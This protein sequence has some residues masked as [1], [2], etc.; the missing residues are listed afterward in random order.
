MGSNRRKN[1]TSQQAREPVDVERLWHIWNVNG[2]DLSLS[3]EICSLLK[4]NE[5]LYELDIFLRNLPLEEEYL[6]NET[7]NRARVKVAFSRG[8]F[9][10][11]YSILQNNYFSST[12]DLVELWDLCHYR[13]E[14]NRRQK[15]L[16]PL[17]RFRIRQRFM[18]PV[19]ILPSGRRKKASLPKESTDKLRVW[20]N[21]NKEHPYPNRDTKI[22]L[23]EQTA[24][25]KFQV[26]TWFANSRRRL[27]GKMKDKSRGSTRAKTKPR[28]TRNKATVVVHS[29][30]SHP[31][32]ENIETMQVPTTSSTTAMKWSPSNQYS[33]SYWRCDCGFNAHDNGLSILFH[34]VNKC[35]TKPFDCAEDFRMKDEDLPRNI[36]SMYEE[37]NH[38][39]ALPHFSGSTHT[40]TSSVGSPRMTLESRGHESTNQDA[41]QILVNLSS[42]FYN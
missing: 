10:S 1:T 34:K 41:A 3:C 16:T 27:H 28:Q 18:P 23:A 33:N 14:E 36:D 22:M 13:E 32:Q 31:D 7:L 12:E 35:L 4:E 21:A 20:F 19:T 37:L 40:I 11:V 9:E 26:S 38:Y 15:P 8:D 2:P 6:V 25:T 42:K 30:L 17:I 29:S 39:P 5:L 24:L